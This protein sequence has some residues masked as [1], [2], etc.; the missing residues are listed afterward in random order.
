MPQMEALDLVRRESVAL[1]LS[2]VGLL[3]LLPLSFAGA[4]SLAKPQRGLLL[5]FWI[6]LASA[7]VICL[8]F[9]VNGRLRLPLHLTLL[10]LAG[11]GASA[12]VRSAFGGEKRRPITALGVGAVLLL[13]LA[14]YPT[15]GPYRNALSASRYAVLEALAGERTAA[16]EWMQIESEIE[17]SRGT[18]WN[19]PAL[20]ETTRAHPDA[21]W[22]L[23]S[24]RAAAWFVLDDLQ[25][26]YADMAPA[27]EAM[28]GNTRCQEGLVE[29]CR[30]LTQSGMGSPEVDAA[31]RRA[32]SRLQGR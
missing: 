23:Q 32:L 15:H 22:L 24:E 29:I 4:L 13:L 25:R 1:R 7:L 2:I 10:P 17:R 21:R 5:P 31:A 6:S 28:P 27:A 20:S 11:I 26:A 18:L 3:I 9:F 19:R 8:V 12:L 14:L 16:R 30:R